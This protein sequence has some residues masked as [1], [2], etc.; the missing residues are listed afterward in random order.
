[1]QVDKVFQRIVGLK[2]FP[3]KRGLC[4]FL[5]AFNVSTAKKIGEANIKLLNSV[6]KGFKEM[7]KITLHLDS[8]VKMAYGNQQRAKKGYNPKKPGK[9]S[10]HPLL[11]KFHTLK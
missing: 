2:E 4:R 5:W 8:H 3:H 10:Y 7:Q 6:R 1:L 11:P 9:K